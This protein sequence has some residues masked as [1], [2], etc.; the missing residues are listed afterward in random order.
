MSG[1]TIVS[2]MLLQQRHMVCE[3]LPS[4][5]SI[6]ERMGLG[7]LYWTSGQCW[8]MAAHLRV[9]QGVI[10]YWVNKSS[11]YTTCYSATFILMARSIYAFK[12]IATSQ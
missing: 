12:G 10:I 7:S 9:G 11:F 3:R 4:S 2:L 8:T 6:E 5:A 1:V